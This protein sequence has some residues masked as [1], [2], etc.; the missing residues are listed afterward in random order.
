M[1]DRDESAT[2]NGSLFSG[3][4]IVGF[5][6]LL[7][8]LLGFIR[9]TALAALWGLSPVKDAY[10]AAFRI[11]NLARALFGEGALS[12]AFTPLFVRE[13]EQHGRDAAM[14]LASSVFVW[15]ARHDPSCWSTPLT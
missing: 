8:R 5:Y 15:L 10:V 3:L 12:A 2:R 13:Q 6:T 1:T 7:S 11:P 4:R 14:R 9:E